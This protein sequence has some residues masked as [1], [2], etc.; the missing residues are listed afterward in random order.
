MA[1]FPS[2]F[3]IYMTPCKKQVK[4]LSSQHKTEHTVTEKQ[5]VFQLVKT[6]L[7]GKGISTSSAEHKQQK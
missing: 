3:S 5:I 7:A 6:H 2:G 4:S 1:A